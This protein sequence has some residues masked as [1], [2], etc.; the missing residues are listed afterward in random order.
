MK[1]LE[2]QKK[3]NLTDEELIKRVVKELGINED[4]AWKMLGI[5]RGEFKGDVIEEDPD[6]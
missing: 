4:E 5:E 1:L 3:F 2:I 6:E